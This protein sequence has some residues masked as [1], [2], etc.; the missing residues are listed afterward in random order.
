MCQM[1][2]LDFLFPFLPVSGQ[3][4]VQ[5]SIASSKYF[6]NSFPSPC[7]KISLLFHIQRT[8]VAS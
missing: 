4:S 5:L 3:S 6:S 1:V 2:T 7:C 8:A